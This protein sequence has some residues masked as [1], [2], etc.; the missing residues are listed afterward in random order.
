MCAILDGR[1]N[2][3]A[4]LNAA[5]EQMPFLYRSL[6][7]DILTICVLYVRLEDTFYEVTIK[8]VFI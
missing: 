8:F 1:G 3:V 5:K 4:R 6:Y 7:G 2:Y